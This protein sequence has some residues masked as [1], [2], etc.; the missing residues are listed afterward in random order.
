MC[1]GVIG[2][3]TAVIDLG[4]M[5]GAIVDLGHRT[6]EAPVVAAGDPAVGDH[7][8][9]HS[10]YVVEVLD[11]ADAAEMLEARRLMVEGAD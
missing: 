7:V 9:V 5:A 3:V 11:P 1:L 4:G 6:V 8:L 10:G 2:I